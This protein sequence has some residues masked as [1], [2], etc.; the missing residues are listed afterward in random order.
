M[1][2]PS[3]AQP[4]ATEPQDPPPAPS[5]R[6]RAVEVVLVFLLS[7]GLTRLFSDLSQV[8]T[9]I[10]EQLFALVSAVFILIPYIVLTRR[11]GDVDA[12]LDA[13]ALTWAGWPRALAYAGVLTIATAVPFFVGYHLWQTE[14]LHQRFTFDLDHYW[15]LPA[16]LEGRPLLQD[17]PEAPEILIWRNGR[18]LHTRWSAGRHRGQRAHE[19]TL[20]LTAHSGLIH[21]LK[22]QA[23]SNDPE[24][25]RSATPKPS[26]TLISNSNAPRSAS[27]MLERVDQLQIQARL[28]G[29]PAT[30]QLLRLGPSQSPPE[31]IGAYDP[32]TQT[33]HLD[34]SLTWLPLIILVQLL[35]IAL[36]EE[37]FYR[38]YIQ[39]SIDRLTDERRWTLPQTPLHL[40]PAI[41]ITSVLFGVGHVIINFNPSRMA[42]FFPSL[43]FGWLRD[44]TGTIVSC[45]VYH[46]ACNLMVEVAS[47]HY[48]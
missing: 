35:L 15:H 20:S 26:I 30:A 21:T 23:W 12:I 45:V 10:A 11:E 48:M 7:L 42:V 27:F 31:T 43:L 36:P 17:K 38:G 37:F 14:V 18:V 22:G 33:L 9:F 4:A 19:L 5:S 25:R 24:V 16:T 8:S 6:R 1:T 39:T 32:T 40:S 44:R 3:P 41:V 29:Q 34:R 28:N 2:E 47:H 46:A 13:H